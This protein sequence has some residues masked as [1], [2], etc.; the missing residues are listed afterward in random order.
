MP[1]VRG[2]E[3]RPGLCCVLGQCSALVSLGAQVPPEGTNTVPRGRPSRPAQFC[4]ELLVGWEPRVAA[5]PAGSVWL[6]GASSAGA[7]PS[8]SRRRPGP[9]SSPVSDCAHFISV[10]AGGAPSRRGLPSQTLPFSLPFSWKEAT[11]SPKSGESG[12]PTQGRARLGGCPPRGGYVAGGAPSL[13]IPA[14]SRAGGL[15][16]G[17]RAPGQG[18]VWRKACT[19]QSPGCPAGRALPCRLGP[20]LSARPLA[21]STPP[22]AGRG[23][24]LLCAHC[25]TASCSPTLGCCGFARTSLS[26]CPG[27][28]TGARKS[29]GACREPGTRGVLH[30][31][32]RLPGDKPALLMVAH[33]FGG[34]C[35]LASPC[36]SFRRVL[37]V[38]P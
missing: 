34:P 37:P 13:P 9:T 38:A 8:L 25:G 12:L 28:R 16:A 15:G 5:S 4:P 36:L 19:C 29:A 6:R 17:P 32:S 22:R 18:Q 11:S 35:H 33:C 24:G 14:C 20:V 26:P 31:Q 1:H 27:P 2:T 30:S 21:V 3:S 7:G 10:R 23:A